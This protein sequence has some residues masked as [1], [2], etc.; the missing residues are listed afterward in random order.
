VISQR[1][2]PRTGGGQ[3]AAFEVLIATNA[4]RNLVREG[5]TH[6]IRNVVA[7]GAKEGMRTLEV[8]LSELVSS[9]DITLDQAVAH[10]LFPKEIRPTLAS[11]TA[12]PVA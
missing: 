10:S 7:T 1:L 4:M 3:V 6:Q 5:K 12:A 9:G 11:V 8:S 2:I